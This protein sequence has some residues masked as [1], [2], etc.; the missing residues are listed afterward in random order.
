MTVQDIRP[1]LGEELS[2]LAEMVAAFSADRLTGPAARAEESDTLPAE[3]PAELVAQGLWTLGV[4]ERYG[5]GGADLLALTV[6][7]QRLAAVTPVA[8]TAVAGVHA[9]VAA[10]ADGAAAPV[11]GVTVA[12]GL[13]VLV[14]TA[15]PL[16]SV[17]VTRSGEGWSVDGT[18]ARV[19]GAGDAALFVLADPEAGVLLIEPSV[20]G[21]AVHAPVGRTGLRGL[22][23][24]PVTFDRVR[25]PGD[26]AL[27]ADRE[28]AHTTR[29]LL[30]GAVAC[31][32]AESAWA[33]A[34][35]YAGSRA[36]FGHLLVEFPAVAAML[37]EM[38]AELAN[39]LLALTSAA[40]GP[41]RATGAA[42]RPA[43]VAGWCARSALRVADRAVQL[44]GGYGYLV[45]YPVERTLRDAVTVRALVAAVAS[46]PPA[47]DIVHVSAK[48]QSRIGHDHGTRR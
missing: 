36:Q 37:D 30:L 19:E 23:P 46:Q 29:L 28:R 15:D 21:C 45:E 32:I 2:E 16:T 18:A 34:R 22:A 33:A 24:H 5:G 20:P 13:P 9:A 1:P 38:A 31:G 48:G 47:S 11:A 8:A 4:S 26:A 35:A 39:R 27:P 3:L 25:L 14:D 40:A 6:A 17:R 42:A 10:V 41:D 43:S 44:H 7:V 12:G